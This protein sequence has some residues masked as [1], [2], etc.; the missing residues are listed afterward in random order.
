MATPTTEV[1]S[2]LE[3]PAAPAAGRILLA[4]Y[5]PPY[6]LSFDGKDPAVG[7][8]DYYATGYLSPGGEGGKH[9]RYGGFLRDRPLPSPNLEAWKTGRA[10]GE[11]A[12]ARTEVAQARRF[13][14][15][16]WAL[17]VLNLGTS[18]NARRQ[19]VQ[20]QACAETPAFRSTLQLDLN[21]ESVRTATVATVAAALVKMLKTG[22]VLEVDGRPVIAPF[23]AEAWTP[24]QHRA[25][26]A[27]VARLYG[28]PYYVPCLVN[29]PG[30]LP[31]YAAVAD[32]LELWGDRVPG[33]KARMIDAGRQVAALG[34]PWW[35]PI[36]AQDYRP[37]DGEVWEAH[38]SR[39]LQALIEAA[40]E[41]GAAVLQANTWND[42]SENTQVAPSRNNGDAVSTLVQAWTAPWREG[43]PA[44]ITR[45]AVVTIRR[46]HVVAAKPT[47]QTLLAAFKAGTPVDVV[48]TL[49]LD[50]AKQTITRVDA[51]L[52]GPST[53]AVQDL[54]YRWAMVVD[55]AP[56]DPRDARIA[57]LEQ[58]VADLDRRLQQALDAVD[59]LE[60]S[61]NAAI[62]DLQATR[63][64]LAA[65]LEQARATVTALGG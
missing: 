33:A 11:L 47:A 30:K 6:P 2:P 7:A 54:G 1:V 28:R 51:P 50:P 39:A 36:A 31:A 32:A 8:G 22:G 34:K 58:Q 20:L 62:T 59:G 44:R 4:H 38:G 64:Q 65:A 43:K 13:G 12:D 26:A 9:A 41:S 3:P 56:A 17:D 40:V 52:T 35:A 23:K 29:W 15:G 60:A 19:L 25:L 21:V 37:R 61:R 55:D 45:R 57:E 49:T 18:D 24:E 53:T 42:Y 48:E 10:A 27:E 16:G 5:F 46:P 14:F 63:R